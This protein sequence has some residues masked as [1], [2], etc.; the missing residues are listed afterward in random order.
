MLIFGWGH[1]RENVVGPVEKLRCPRCGRDEFW[2][3][4][5]VRTYVSFFFVPVIPYRTEHLIRCPICQVVS[6]VSDAELPRR[7]EQA[8][9]LLREVR[10]S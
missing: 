1:R 5:E 10:G 2:E 3:L 4:V 8:A 7:Q 9:R 6:E